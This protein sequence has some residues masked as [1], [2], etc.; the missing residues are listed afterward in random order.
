MCCTVIHN[1]K[2]LFYKAGNTNLMSSFCHF[3]CH[4]HERDLGRLGDDWEEE[5]DM[6][7][8]S[9]AILLQDLVQV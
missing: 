1:L 6:A 7:L 3:F 4:R 8:P 2:M 5:E 9:A